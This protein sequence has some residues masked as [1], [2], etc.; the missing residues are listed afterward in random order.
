M[1]EVVPALTPLALRQT[2]DAIA[3]VQL[4]DGA[5]PEF[6]GGVTNPWNHVEAAMALD[7]GGRSEAAERAYS[8]LAATQHA[9]GSWAA[10]YLGDEIVDRTRDANFNSYVAFGV[11]HHFV[12][13]VDRGFLEEMWPVVDRAVTFT[14]ALQ[15]PSGAIAWARDGH[16][17]IWPSALV[18]SCSCIY[19]S[20]RSGVQIAST[21]GRERPEWE[22]SLALLGDTIRRGDG[23]FQ[24]KDRFSMDWYYPVLARAV[25]GAEARRRLN[26][27]WESFVVRNLGARCVSDR[28]WITAGE[29]AELV[30]ALWV[31]GME[32]EANMLLGWAQH[33]RAEDGAY[34]IGAT[35]LD[36]T[37][38]P[39][40][41]PTWGSGAV[42]LAADVLAGGPTSHCL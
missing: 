18:T 3:A 4:A 23:P 6:G 7:V 21:L 1:L 42:V 37:V 36:A 11:W 32:V 39:R 17:R 16:G 8:W 29:T 28:P 31:A 26:E 9:D 5:I 35:F 40:Q 41:K 22:L 33:L 30:M 12:A 15:L 2:V 38:W 34:W 19:M 14:L 25:Q 27:R 13:T 24:R 10:G 20:L